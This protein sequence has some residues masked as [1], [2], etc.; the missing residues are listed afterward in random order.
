MKFISKSQAGIGHVVL[1]AVV[2]LLI[3]A[4]GFTAMRVINTE[5]DKTEELTNTSNTAVVVPDKLQSKD[6]LNK[7]KASLNQANLDSNMNPSSL[8]GDVSSLL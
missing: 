6:D 5:S 2:A 3:A 7:I 1:L 8:D 4:I